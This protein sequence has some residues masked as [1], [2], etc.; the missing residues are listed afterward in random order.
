[1][2][3]KYY[4]EALAVNPACARCYLNIGRIYARKND[5]KQAIS[6]LDKAVVTDPKD[7][8]LLSN[9]A[10]IKEMSGDKFGALADHDKA[11]ALSP[12]NADSY[13]ER[14]IY[15][16]NQNYIALALADFNKAI[17]LA[18]DHSYPYFYRSKIKF[19]GNDFDGALTD[20]NKAIKLDNQQYGL[21]N[22]R[23]TIY[24]AL[25]QSVKALED[26]SK[27]IK[28]NPNGF[29]G[30]L[31]R[32]EVYYQLENMDASCEDYAQAKAMAQKE[33]INDP[34]LFK[35]IEDAMLDFC[36][37]SKASFY[38]QRGVAFYNLKQYAK[39]LAIYIAGLQKF[40]KNAMILSFKGSAY[41]AVKDYKNAIVAYES[42]LANKSSLTTELANNIRYSNASQQERQSFYNASI[43]SIYY[44]IAACHIY[45]EKL[46]EA[47]IV[48]NH[49]I[50]IAPNIADFK[51]E[52]YYDRRGNIY[53]EMNKYE[54]AQSD[55]NQSIKINQNY[56]PAYVSRAIAKISAVEN[57]KQSN[58]I[59]SAKLPN[60]P[61]RINWAVKP[62]KSLKAVD[63]NIISGLA[64]CNKG[65]ALD[66]NIGFAYYVR[67]QIKSFLASPDYCIDLIKAQKMGVEVETSLIA[68][69]K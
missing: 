17:E 42:A 27:V 58:A 6:Y 13:A 69:C 66:E 16:L 15:N 67:G 44:H 4:R 1:M 39:A 24:S 3:E 8:L 34:T 28:L 40:P 25:K 43:A 53:L 62:Q 26:Y 61:F 7:N 33:K 49:A 32:A 29:L 35:K 50:E 14:G 30:Y 31:N 36:D 68:A 64:D 52:T 46:V 47:L 65:I 60:Q 59:V 37:A 54:L 21:Y 11:I 45:N 19:K 41:L 23:G 48:M 12:K 18:P 56:A 2:G 63:P 9:R 55:F 20:I 5:F 57:V 51:K 22:F 10:K 38:Y